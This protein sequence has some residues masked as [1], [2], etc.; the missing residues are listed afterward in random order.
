MSLMTSISNPIVVSNLGDMVT[1]HNR[2][3]EM[4][5][6]D[7]IKLARK[8]KRATFLSLLAIAGTLYLSKKEKETA[9]K[10]DQLKESHAKLESDFERYVM[11]HSEYNKENTYDDELLLD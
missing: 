8:N 9:D 5:A 3:M 4:V 6:R 7:V 11:D 1:L 2:N 10:L